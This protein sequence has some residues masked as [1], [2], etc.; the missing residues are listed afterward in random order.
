MEKITPSRRAVLGSGTASLLVGAA[1]ATAA[2]G[3][4]WRLLW[5]LATMQS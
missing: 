2:R 1:I 3:R 5:P 4:L